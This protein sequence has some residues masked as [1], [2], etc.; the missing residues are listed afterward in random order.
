[1]NRLIFQLCT[2]KPM[3]EPKQEHRDEN[4]NPNR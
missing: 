4:A 3:E 2:E 1:M